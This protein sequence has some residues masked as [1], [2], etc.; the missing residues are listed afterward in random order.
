[1]RIQFDVLL[2]Q[3]RQTIEA[4]LPVPPREGELVSFE[5][6]DDVEMLRVTT[7]EWR[8]SP[9]GVMAVVGVIGD[10]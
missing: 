1:M 5:G 3:E 4:E 10:V 2:R 7:V 6:L 9:T 8:V